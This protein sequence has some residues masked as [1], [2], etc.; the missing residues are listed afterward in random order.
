MEEEVRKKSSF[1]RNPKKTLVIIAVTLFLVIDFTT[2]FVL[3]ALDLFTPAY[4]TA[5]QHEAVYRR[6]HP[7]FHHT[8]ARNIEYDHAVWGTEVY[9]IR[10]NSLG[11]KDERVRE[12]ALEA[13]QPRIIIT[14]DS[15][16]E[17]LGLEFKDTFVGHISNYYKK[18]DVEVLNAGLLSYSPEIHLTKTRYFLE[19]EGLEF[20][21]LVVF[22]DMSDM[23]D[24]AMGYN[25]DLNRPVKKITDREK[26]GSTRPVHKEKPSLKAFLNQHTVFIAQLRNLAAYYRI[27]RKDLRQWRQ[28]LNRPRATW[29]LDEELYEKFGRVGQDKAAQH[30]RMLKKLL[31]KYGIELTVVVYP[32]PDQIY[33]K[34]LDSIHV[35]FWRRWT[36]SNGVGFVNLF[37][38]FINNK[39]PEEVIK[40][41]FIRGDVHWNKL[42]HQYIAER[43]LHYFDDTEILNRKN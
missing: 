43:F 15:F 22:I 25:I 42:G 38:D 28:S 39:D 32:W 23:E 34:D 4:M 26:T 9:T 8:L 2:A 16:T 20:D 31:D 13:K 7:V 33:R 24:E 21:H 12:V 30:M 11:F 5:G 29:T 40:T 3:K 10:T 6:P 41:Y 1:E 35:K 18:R 19:A 14:G 37:P 27:A 17:G 36:K